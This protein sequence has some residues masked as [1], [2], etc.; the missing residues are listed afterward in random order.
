MKIDIAS[1]TLKSLK[2]INR[3]EE[4]NKNLSKNFLKSLNEI[5]RLEQELKEAEQREKWLTDECNNLF[6]NYM[7]R[8]Q[9]FVFQI[10]YNIHY[11]QIL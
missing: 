9:G 4:E 6:H 11:T 7:N 10:H 2:E 1:N 8:Y 5:N 3:L